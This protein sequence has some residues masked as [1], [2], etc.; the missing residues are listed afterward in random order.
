MNYFRFQSIFRNQPLISISFLNVTGEKLDHR[1][2]V[3]WQQAGRIERIANNWYWFTEKTPLLSDLFTAANRIYAPS[4]I[5]LETALGYHGMIP[6]QT[7]AIQS[8]ATRKTKRLTWRNTLFT[9]SQVKPAFMLD[10]RLMSVNG[11]TIRMAGPEKALLDLCYLRPDL[12]TKDDF[13]GLRLNP[14]FMKNTFNWQHA[15]RIT[16]ALGVAVL[17]QK[18]RMLKEVYG[19]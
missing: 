19:A 4:Y 7:F 1:R 14:A 11:Q 2:L 9:W 6:E 3:E 10:Y 13:E 17:V 18:M 8:V 16:E 12:H 5:S 15:Q